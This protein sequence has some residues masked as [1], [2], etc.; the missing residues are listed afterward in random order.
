MP[1]Y[2]YPGFSRTWV[3]IAI[4][5]AALV[6]LT[7][8]VLASL[9]GG[10]SEA[11]EEEALRTR[12]TDQA[13]AAAYNATPL[14][15][16]G[17]PM[18][19]TNSLAHNLGALFGTRVTFIRPDG[20][21][22]G[23]SEEDPTRMENHA[24]RPE[25][26][27]VL[28]NPSPASSSVVGISSRLSATVHRRLLYVAVGVEDPS[29]PSH[30]IGVA[31]VAYPMT[32]VEQVRDTLWGNLALAVLLVS[33]P[34]ALLGALLARSIV[35]PLTILMGTAYRFGKGDLSVRS[36]TSGGEI[37]ELSR[38]FNTMAE[39]LSDTIHR[40]TVERNQMAAVLSHMHDGILITD[41]QGHLEAMNAAAA[42]LFGTTEAKAAGRSLIEVTRSH[43]LHQAMQTALLQP[44][45]DRRRLQIDAGGRKLAAVLTVVPMPAATPGP[46]PGQESQEVGEVGEVAEVRS[47]AGLV[48]V[49]D[50]TELHRLERARRDFVANIGHELRTPL[51]SIKL[52]VE[53][54]NIAVKDDPEAAQGFL[55]RIDV[56][57]DGLTQLVRELLEL[58]RIE[59][60]QVQLNLQPV[61]VSGLLERAAGR[62]RTQSEQAGVNLDV[63]IA[64]SIPPANA[65]PGRVEQ[66][67]V[68]LLHNAVKFTEPGGR[69]TLKAVPHDSSV[70]ISV[71]DTGVGIPPDD[72]PRIFER[73]YKVDK[74]RTSGDTREGGTG[75]GLSITKHIVQ[76]HGGQIWATSDLGRGTTFFFTL[77]MAPQHP[78]EKI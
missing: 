2:T 57:V 61:E 48:V 46:G 27:Q 59:S 55:H 49:Q 41:A 17:V 7:A 53:T 62:L 44:G 28:A 21:V 54:L 16:A 76:A 74:A 51:A 13:R 14:F 65:D 1:K 50:V 52:L 70:L 9:L 39:R 42:Q 31:R 69:I 29:A 68:N 6:L 67:L 45:T 22:V 33:L 56:E 43:E 5:Y 19:A 78:P 8:G 77:P 18:T 47:Y 73:F 66:V 25:V 63:Q 60:G 37:G 3:R 26:A 12:L 35:G 71:E 10:E 72:L 11:R 15:R 30:I 20:S 34:A 38:E 4:S 36:L 24:G 32:A 23:D 75:L 64:S 58:S 40:R